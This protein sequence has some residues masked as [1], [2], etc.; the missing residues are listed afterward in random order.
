MNFNFKSFI[1]LVSRFKTATLLN[2]LGLSI[3]ITAFIMIIMQVDYDYNFDRFH[4]NSDRI[5]RVEHGKGSTFAV[6]SRDR[7]SVV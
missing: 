4:K 7:K 2:I 1:Y 3:A 6:I 5:Y